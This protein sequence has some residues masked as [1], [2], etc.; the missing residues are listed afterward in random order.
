MHGIASYPFHV[1]FTVCGQPVSSEFTRL[2][3]II[4][5]SVMVGFTHLYY[6]SNYCLLLD[7]EDLPKGNGGTMKREPS[8][9]QQGH[10][11]PMDV[12]SIF[13]QNAQNMHY[14]LQRYNM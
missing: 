10:R 6:L 14:N 13:H 11:T 9:K 2:G 8:C 4:Y 5:F 3:V 7:A 1:V 12:I